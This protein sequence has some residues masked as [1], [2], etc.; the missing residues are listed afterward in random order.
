MSAQNDA[1]A[2]APSIE[3][4]NAN[5]GF[6][7]TLPASWKGYS[8]LTN[9][10][11]GSDPSSQNFTHGPELRIRHPKWTKENPY[12]DIPIMIFTHAEWTLVTEEKLIASP[13]PFPPSELGRNSRYVFA[14]PPRYNYDLSIGY[15]EV[16]SLIQ[17]KS[18][19]APCGTS[20]AQ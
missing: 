4:R 14:L 20:A 17:H 10:W 19:H 13:A 9:Q 15:Q 2:P 1:A 5:Y 7:V 6:C 18:L 3:Y 11:E 8:I 12:E 16:E